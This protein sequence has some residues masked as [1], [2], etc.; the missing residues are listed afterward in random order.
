MTKVELKEFFKLQECQD[1]VNNFC[2]KKKVVKKE[3]IPIVDNETLRYL[4][5]LEYQEE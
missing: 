3:I 4:I 1:F 2:Q 5:C